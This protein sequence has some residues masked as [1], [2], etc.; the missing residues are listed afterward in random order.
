MR[1]V[2]WALVLEFGPAVGVRTSAPCGV[3]DLEHIRRPVADLARNIAHR[4]DD[5]PDDAAYVRG[6]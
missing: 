2:L 4:A 6:A 1:A 3:A 5:N